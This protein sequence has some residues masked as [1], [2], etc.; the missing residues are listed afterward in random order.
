MPGKRA[1]MPKLAL[2]LPL[3]VAAS[4][5]CAGCGDQA[6]TTRSSQAASTPRAAASAPRLGAGDR[7]A[8]AEIGRAFSE[9]NAAA[10]TWIDAL[11][12]GRRR[13]LATAPHQLAR[14]S[15]I[16]GRVAKAAAAISAPDLRRAAATLARTRRRQL[17]ILQGMTAAVRRHAVGPLH[18]LQ[19]ALDRAV[20]RDAAA[21][22]RYASLKVDRY[23]L[24]PSH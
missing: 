23:K 3:V 19:R 9:W 18:R 10:Q 24:A 7:A 6:T 8:V 17:T 2:S 4:L 15:P 13:F 14:L 22:H 11:S 21:A 20:A 16:P 12:G 5:A 1:V